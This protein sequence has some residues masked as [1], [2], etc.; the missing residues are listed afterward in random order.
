MG[1]HYKS[2]CSRKRVNW[3][4]LAQDR[5]QRQAVVKAVLNLRVV[6]KMEDCYDT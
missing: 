5:T 2:G 1:G 4:Q 6:Y 3:I